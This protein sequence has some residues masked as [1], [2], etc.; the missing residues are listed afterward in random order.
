MHPDQARWNHRYAQQGLKSFGRTASEWLIQ[1][2]DLLMQQTKGPAL[3]LACGNGRNAFYLAQLG[4]VVD[5][6]DISDVAIQWVQKQ[7]ISQQLAVRAIHANLEES[8]LPRPAYELIIGF[9][10]LQRTIFPRLISSLAPNGLLIYQTRYLDEIRILKREA[11]PAYLLGYNEL[12][13]HCQG[14]RVLHYQESIQQV[15]PSQRQKA[16]AS[17]VARNSTFSD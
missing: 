15:G 9:N 16:L 13:D 8:E 4:F 6:V 3:D 10:Y 2:K 5:A 11:N 1:H 12:L 14:L 7:A 17:I